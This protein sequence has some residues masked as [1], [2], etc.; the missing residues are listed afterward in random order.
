MTLNEYIVDVQDI[1]HDPNANFYSLSQLARWINIGRSEVAKNGRC[2]RRLPPNSAAVASGL[3]TSG[4]AGYTTATVTIGA[5]DSVQLGTEQATA[6]AV[7]SGGQVVSITITNAG[8]GYVAVPTV[9]IDGDGTG[10]AVTAVLEPHT[11]TVVE[12]EVYP[13]ADI[14]A[15]MQDGEA[16]LGNLLGIQS[17]SVSWGALKPTLRRTDWSTFQSYL[18]SN[19]TAYQNYPQ[20]WAQ[21][22]QGVTGS[23][24]LWPIPSL[25]TAMD[26]DCYFGVQDLSSGQTVDLIPEPWQRSVSYYAAY[27]AYLNA[28]RT[29]DARSML[30]EHIR[31][32]T[33]ARAAVST[34]MI[35]DPYGVN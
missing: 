19:N 35:P 11:T 18:R 3:V 16:G 24:Y 32:M 29:D 31:L 6:T 4:G 2:V 23:F 34:D 27:R 25:V 30:A 5:P 1:L 15:I 20:V 12:Q 7:L 17:I 22:G 21:Y 28:Q 10:A 9:T 14:A 13:L 33:E 8:A 26:V